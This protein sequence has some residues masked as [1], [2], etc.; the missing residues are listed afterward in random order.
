MEGGLSLENLKR[1][2]VV[3]DTQG[4]SR[5]AVD[6]SSLFIKKNEGMSRICPQNFII[7]CKQ[8]M[9]KDFKFNVRGRRKRRKFDAST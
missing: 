3:G 2:N 4:F 5:Y 7:K 1:I 6:S 8:C 9:E